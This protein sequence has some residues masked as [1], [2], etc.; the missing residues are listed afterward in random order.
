MVG[1]QLPV[2]WAYMDLIAEAIPT[3]DKWSVS[4]LIIEALAMWLC[5]SPLV[6]AF[7]IWVTNL[8]QRKRDSGLCDLLV[9]ASAALLTCLA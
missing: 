2:F 1:S 8:L 9:S 6:V 3:Q 5:A 7:V 4:A